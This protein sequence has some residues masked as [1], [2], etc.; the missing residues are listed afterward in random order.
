MELSKDFNERMRD[1]LGDEYPDFEKA[2]S[3]SESYIAIRVNGKRKIPDS[4][5]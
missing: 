5:M 1:L 2:F 4:S 3:E